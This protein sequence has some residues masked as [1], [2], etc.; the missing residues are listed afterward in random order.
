MCMRY[1][2]L[3][4]SPEFLCGLKENGFDVTRS[5]WKDAMVVDAE[6]KE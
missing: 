3:I 2:G 6:P 4:T 5:Q 1:E